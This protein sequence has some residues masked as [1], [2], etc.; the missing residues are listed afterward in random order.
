MA[1]EGECHIVTRIP[2]IIM[3]FKN[4]RMITG[5]QAVQTC[6]RTTELDHIITSEPS[7]G[8][9]RTAAADPRQRP[10]RTQ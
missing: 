7:F 4:N 1:K 3:K 2:I 5:V 10:L 8:S 9:R 6:T